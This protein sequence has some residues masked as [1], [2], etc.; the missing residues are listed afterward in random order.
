MQQL[1]EAAGPYA[2]DE[3]HGLLC[4]ELDAARCHLQCNACT[5]SAYTAGPEV[6]VD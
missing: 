5:H 1:D 2:C 4:Q 6:S 3:E